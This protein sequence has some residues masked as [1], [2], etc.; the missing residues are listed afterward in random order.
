MSRRTPHPGPTLALLEPPPSDLAARRAALVAAHERL[1]VA[2]N[3]PIPFFHDLDPLSELV[4]ALLSHRT[5]N[6]DSGRAFRALRELY[7]DWGALRDAPTDEVE[8]A[9][10]AVTWPEQKA[11]RIQ[12][13][14]RDITAARGG[15]LSLDFLADLSVRQARDWLESFDG[16]GPKT[17]AAVLLFSRLRRPA[18]PVD[19]HHHRVAQRLGLLPPGLAVGPAHANLEAL[20]PPEWGTQ[21]IYD[22]HEVLMLHGQRCCHYDKPACGRCVV[23]DLCPTGLAR[24]QAAASTPAPP[25]AGPSLTE[26]APLGQ[27]QPTGPSLTE[28]ASVGQGQPAGPRPTEGASVGQAQP[29][30]PSLRKVRP[31]AR[32]AGE[33]RPVALPLF[34]DRG[35]AA[36]AASET[37]PAARPAVRR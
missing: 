4:S 31:A 37:L 13:V 32:S 29:A 8:R 18:M 30:G 21:E 11:P 35:A 6:A 1:C 22:H 2:Y 12:K 15:E 10:A 23:L 7:P 24:Q 17:S 27:A 36:P 19:S 34:G 9:I 28:G 25:A 26:G 14:L 5:R 33:R 20:L 16:V 3:A